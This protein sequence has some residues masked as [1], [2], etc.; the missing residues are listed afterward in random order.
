MGNWLAEAIWASQFVFRL[1]ARRSRVQF[2]V[3]IHWFPGSAWELTADEALPRESVPAS[4]WHARR[5]L[6]GSSIPGRAWE[7]VK[8]IW[9]L[10]FRI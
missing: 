1:A 5:S 2:A 8:Q 7:R 3:G 10:G 6:E 9:E 4:I